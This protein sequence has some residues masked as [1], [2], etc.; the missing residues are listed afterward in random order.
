MSEFF[1]GLYNSFITSDFAQDFYVNF[2][3][4]DRW[5]LLLEGVKTTLILTIL[6]IIVGTVLGFL[7]AL[8]KMSKT[9]ILNI[10]AKVYIEIIRGTPSY[11]Q[12]LII[13]LVVFASVDINKIVVGM[14]A[15]GMN[16]SAYIAEIIR[17]GI[18][19][20]DRGQTEAGRSLGLTPVQTMRHIILPQAFKN[21]LPT[22][23]NEFIVL[24]K[25]TAIAGNISVYELT[26]Q[27]TVI[28]SRTYNAFFPLI[29]AAIL[30]FI[31][32]FSLSKLFG[33][34]ERRMKAS[35]IR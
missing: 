12:I 23:A 13:Y 14:I 2:I 25:E 5:L 32:T 19:A 18:E 15:F 8:M 6:S 9:K 4:A 33:Y 34:L 27:A 3:A 31:M 1:N 17:A 26:K 29:G 20:V 30:Y 22:Y 35:D 21:I 7:L 24:L 10:P 28:Q 11:V 16:S